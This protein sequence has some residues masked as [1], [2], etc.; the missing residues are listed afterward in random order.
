[1]KDWKE[2]IRRQ[3]DLATDEIRAAALD[4]LTAGDRLI[5]SARII[6]EL[7]PD[8]VVN[9]RYEV[10]TLPRGYRQVQV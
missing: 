10:D 1:M 7:D 9:V 4:S 2:T 6:I 8:K 3:I 5:V